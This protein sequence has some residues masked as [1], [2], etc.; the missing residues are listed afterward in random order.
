[1]PVQVFPGFVPVRDP[2]LRIIEF[3]LDVSDF[4]S[5]RAAADFPAAM[6]PGPSY[7]VAFARSNGKRRDPLVVDAMT[8]R[9]LML[10]DGTRT[11]AELVRD[12]APGTDVSVEA[13]NLEW[14]ENLIVYGLIRLSDELIDKSAAPLP[15]EGMIYGE[16][17]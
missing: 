11:A 6:T 13:T 17:L 2:Q 7:I 9:I 3:D 12:L 4:L 5:A 8:A 16:V 10:S 15:D 1:M 14:I